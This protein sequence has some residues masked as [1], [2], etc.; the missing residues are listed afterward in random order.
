MSRGGCQLFCGQFP[1][2]PDRPVN[3]KI[4]IVI[5]QVKLAA[6]EATADVGLAAQSAFQ[7]KGLTIAK[8]FIHLCEQQP[9]GANRSHAG[10]KGR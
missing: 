9:R 1:G 6:L 3:G 2:V 8:A 5:Q 10:I 4:K 7:G